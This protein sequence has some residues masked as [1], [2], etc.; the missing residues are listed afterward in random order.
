MCVHVSTRDRAVLLDLRKSHMFSVHDFSTPLFNQLSVCVE[1]VLFSFHIFSE[2]ESAL[3]LFLF[4]C[5]V[6]SHLH[7]QPHCPFYVLPPP[8]LPM[9]Q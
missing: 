1:I 9:K 6:Q 8:P 4:I 2:I 5:G 7:Y 3:L